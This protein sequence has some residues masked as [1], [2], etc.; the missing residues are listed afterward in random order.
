[1]R[2]GVDSVVPKY[3]LYCFRIYL[4]SAAN[5]LEVEKV[6]SKEPKYERGRDTRVEWTKKVCLNKQNILPIDILNWLPIDIS[7][8]LCFLYKILRQT[9]HLSFEF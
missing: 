2:R 7:P 4:P 3:F 9:T 5:K 8:S 1:M 6:S